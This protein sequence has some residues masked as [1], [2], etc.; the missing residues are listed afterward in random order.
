MGPGLISRSGGVHQ[1]T[2]AAFVA[3]PALKRRIVPAYQYFLPLMTTS[4]AG[5]RTRSSRDHLHKHMADTLPTQARTCALDSNASSSIGCA[6]EAAR[7]VAYSWG[8]K[9][10][11]SVLTSGRLIGLVTR[12]LITSRLVVIGFKCSICVPPWIGQPG[13]FSLPP[14]IQLVRHE[15]G[16]P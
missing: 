5:N 9:N 7:D 13:G 16:R 12:R 3:R 6:L 15:S 8:C 10:S 2:A 14:R 1:A 11:P 4:G